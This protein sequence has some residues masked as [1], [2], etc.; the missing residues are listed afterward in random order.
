MLEACWQC[1]VGSFVYAST[2]KALRPYTPHI[3]AASKKFGEYLTLMA[4]RR[5]RVGRYSIARFTHVVDNSLVLRRFVEMERMGVLGLH[6]SK[7][8]F[9]TQSAAEAAHLLLCALQQSQL[10]RPVEVL[11][12]RD[13]G[14]PTSLLDLALGVVAR[15]NGRSA[16]YIRGDE[17]GYE[18]SYY[19]GLYD[20]ET[21]ADVSPLLNAFE[22]TD[23]H[24]ISYADVDASPVRLDLAENIDDAIRK[25]E[26]V[27]LNAE[28]SQAR[29]AV[30]DASFGLLAATIASAEPSVLRRL[31]HLTFPLRPTMSEV[32]LVI[33][34]TIRAFLSFE[35]RE[36]DHRR[37][38]SRALGSF[39]TAH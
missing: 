27:C 19:P 6:D 7:T 31:A 11:A 30:R 22:A 28:E 34:D 36:L 32:D 15:G 1:G 10:G 8:V 38:A 24:A 23:A 2:G 5:D 14:L 29:N 3:Y 13:L 39:F 18:D 17:P 25:V 9:Y 21:A 20:P 33:D 16:L 12:I 37:V 26:T 35:T 4:S